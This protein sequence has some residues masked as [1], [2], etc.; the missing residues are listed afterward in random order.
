VT[1]ARRD[2]GQAAVEFAIVTP[3]VIVVVLG[4]IQV[5]SLA[6]KQA[7]LE[8][9]ARSGA[10]A[11]SVA[12]DPA[13]AAGAAIGRASSE[14]ALTVVTSTQEGDVTVRVTLVDPTSVPIVGAFIGDVEL[15]ASATMPREPPDG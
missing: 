12:A 11:A 13:G 5:V 9:L 7:A 6:A 8:Q 4:V 1:R 10:R 15:T 2:R 14:S 3:A